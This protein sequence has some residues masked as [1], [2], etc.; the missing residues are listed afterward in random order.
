MT[1]ELAPPLRLTERGEP[2]AALTLVTPLER[3]LPGVTQALPLKS[4]RSF[5]SVS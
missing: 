5:R 3:L 2:V 4:I 1:G